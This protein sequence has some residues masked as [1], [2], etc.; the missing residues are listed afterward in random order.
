[1]SANLYERDFHAWTQE[2][3]AKL[4]TGRLAELDISHLTEELESMGATE[5]REVINRLT[6]LVMHLL[7]WQFQPSHRGRSWELTIKIQRRDVE[8]VLRQNPSLRPRLTEFFPDAYQTAVLRAA[9]E[10]RIDVERF[11]VDPPFT[12]EQVMSGEFWPE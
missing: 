3:A 1:M 8:Q 6:V 9:K 7:K 2:Q 12:I 5:R 4:R 11:P 10:T